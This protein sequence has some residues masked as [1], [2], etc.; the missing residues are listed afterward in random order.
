MSRLPYFDNRLPLRPPHQASAGPRSGPG[1]PFPERP[2]DWYGFPLPAA[3]GHAVQRQHWHTYR[4]ANSPEPNSTPVHIEKLHAG[5]AG[6]S[7]IRAPDRAESAQAPVRDR[8][9]YQLSAVSS[10]GVLA[11]D[12]QTGGRPQAII[13]GGTQGWARIAELGE[14]LHALRWAPRTSARTTRVIRSAGGAG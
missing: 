11:A 7:R 14:L 10:P 6:C 5:T 12:A 3:A 4:R 8:Y 2:A 9:C 1:C 13:A